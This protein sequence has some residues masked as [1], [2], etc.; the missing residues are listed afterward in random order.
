MKQFEGKLERLFEIARLT[1]PEKDAGPMPD[2]LKTRILAHWRASPAREPA[3]RSLALVFRLSLAC[4]TI[5]MLGSVAWSY[6]ELTHDPD[7]E[8]AIANYELRDEL[9]T[10]V[11]P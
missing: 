1:P 10:E 6:D 8:V 2:Y 11:T 9:R 4:A 7:N 3:P 5:V